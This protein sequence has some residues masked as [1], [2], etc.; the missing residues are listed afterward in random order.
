MGFPLLGMLVRLDTVPHRLGM[1][2]RLR[3][4]VRL[5]MGRLRLDMEGCRRLG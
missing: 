5:C 2:R 1:V 4:T 3:G